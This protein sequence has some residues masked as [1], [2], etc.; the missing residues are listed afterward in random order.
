M[1]STEIYPKGCLKRLMSDRITEN[2]VSKEWLKIII[3][4]V[5][6]KV[7]LF[8]NLKLAKRCSIYGKYI[9]WNLIRAQEL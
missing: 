9:L 4:A 2:K 1:T 3:L 6:E 7:I 8:I 5:P